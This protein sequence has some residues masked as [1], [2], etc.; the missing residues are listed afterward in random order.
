[1]KGILSEP[2]LAAKAVAQS[3][4]YIIVDGILY[5]NGQKDRTARAVTPC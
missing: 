1:L 4:L 5:Y 2:E 3:S